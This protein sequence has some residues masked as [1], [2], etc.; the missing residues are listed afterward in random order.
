MSTAMTS[1]EPRSR[2][3]RTGRVL[4]PLALFLGLALIL[5]GCLYSPNQTKAA[6]L[7]NSSR[8]A[9]GK[10]KLSV[11]L[12]MSNKAQAWANHLANIGQLQHSNLASGV[13]GGWKALGENVGFAG[14]VNK[15]HNA[16]MNS[17]GH[18]ANILNSKWTHLGTGTRLKG[19]KVYV[20]QVFGKY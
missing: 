7:V 8:A 9:H 5:S 13:P 18:R 12:K 3:L 14:T 17:A 20:V 11:N 19:G 10:A 4:K 1:V 16:F 6:N 15:T 2:S